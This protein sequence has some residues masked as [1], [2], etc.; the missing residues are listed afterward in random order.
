M[1]L[2]RVA[3]CKSI[4]KLSKSNRVLTICHVW[5]FLIGSTRVSAT[6][7]HIR[8][9]KR[10]SC[11]F[12]SPPTP[13]TQVLFIFL[14]KTCHLIYNKRGDITWQESSQYVTEQCQSIQPYVTCVSS[15]LAFAHARSPSS[16]TT[17]P[18]KILRSAVRSH[19]FVCLHYNG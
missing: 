10:K 8:L 5:T 18:H 16:E 12:F 3:I 9:P 14:S 4:K 1:Q 19:S 13:Q 6:E 17:T 15:V 2:I 7:G 11:S